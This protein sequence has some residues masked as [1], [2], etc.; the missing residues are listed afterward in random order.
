MSLNTNFPINI[1]FNI[2][3]SSQAQSEIGRVGDAAGRASVQAQ[4]LS[5]SFTSLAGAFTGIMV[6]G[7]IKGLFESVIQPTIAYTQVM[8]RIKTLTG[9]NESQ[10]ASYRKEISRVAEVT[11]FGQQDTAE[12]MLIL[13]QATGSADAAM[14][15]LGTTADIAMAAFGKLSM[16]EAAQMTASMVKSFG[17]SGDAISQ[18][19]D[20]LYAIARATGTPLADFKNV[21]GTLGS[22]GLKSAQS[23]EEMAG[24]FALIHRAIPS[25]L[26]SVTELNRLMN[27]L[28]KGKGSSALKV[29]GID[30]YDSH[31]RLKP[32]LSV[33]TEMATL[34]NR[35]E[36]AAELFRQ[37]MDGAVG[38]AASKALYAGLSQLTR[39]LALDNGQVIKLA[40]AHQYLADK[41][42]NSTG[43]MRKAGLDYQKSPEG[44]WQL[45]Q[46]SIEKLKIQIGT[47]LLP[48]ALQVATGIRAITDTITGL[49]QRFSTFGSLLRGAA[50]LGGVWA[51]TSAFWGAV[52][53]LKVV[54]LNLVEAILK[55]QQLGIASRSVSYAGALSPGGGGGT[56]LAAG[57]GG[58]TLGKGLLGSMGGIIGLASKAIL[59]LFAAYTAGSLIQD[60]IANQVED[61]KQR[62]DKAGGEKNISKL[63]Q[64]IGRAWYHGGAITN[65][66]APALE[67]M[68]PDK[69]AARW[70]KDFMQ[71]STWTRFWMR[72][73]FIDEDTFS[74]YIDGLRKEHEAEDKSSELMLAAADKMKTA[75]GDI[76]SAWQF[77]FDKVNEIMSQ[78]NKLNKYEPPVI[79][80]KYFEQLQTQ[81]SIARKRVTDPREQTAISNMLRLMSRMDALQTKSEQGIISPKE[82][83]EKASIAATA[84][85]LAQRL[86]LQHPGMISRNLVKNW[87]KYVAAPMGQEGTPENLEWTARQVALDEGRLLSN[88]AMYV[89]GW[90]AKAFGY[91]NKAPLWASS[92]VPSPAAEPTANM[93]YADPLMNMLLG[94]ETSSGPIGKGARAAEQNKQ[95]QGQAQIHTELKKL[96]K[97]LEGVIKVSVTNVESGRDAL[98]TP[99]GMHP[100]M[101][102]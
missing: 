34:F 47:E 16:P 72:A 15:S 30:A 3:G 82:M 96:N 57:A 84:T 53:I 64:G 10:M 23:F 65:A 9:A 83:A 33:F 93:S 76:V 43:L 26:R 55:T 39:G 86:N 25:E 48:I 51:L 18:A 69:L 12:A 81:L 63:E 22:S 60:Y 80:W 35:G 7:K 101:N 77:G 97:T 40:N 56:L 85:G 2:G 54:N 38:A 21:L 74:K 94:G 19:G 95:A 67:F 59:P 1:L 44:Q 14:K 88:G 27:D 24:S 11:S 42:K 66:L 32:M 50:I 45:T 13:R 28:S 99:N 73:G 46:D 31:G 75:A 70:N 61:T 29:L 68:S 98:S 17:L 91:N 79:H 4:K 49:F 90:N 41:V 62:N 102:T 92:L 37:K 100:F 58:A 5:S 87:Q 36:N 6:A 71:Q 89:P 78:V 52:R 8:Q 20:K